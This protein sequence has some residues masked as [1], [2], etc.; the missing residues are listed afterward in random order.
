MTKVDGDPFGGFGPRVKPGSKIEK[1][2]TSWAEKQGWWSIKIAK[3]NKRGVPDRFYMKDGNPVFV[4]FKGPRETVKEQQKRRIAEI[5]KAGGEAWAC[6]SLTY[7][8]ARM[9]D[10]EDYDR[11]DTGQMD[12]LP[13]RKL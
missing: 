12:A 2:A 7:F 11:H 13:S 8:K 1:D 4:E 10:G 3:T 6:R 5:I 9:L